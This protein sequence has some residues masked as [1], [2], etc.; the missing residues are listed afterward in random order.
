MRLFVAVDLPET[1]VQSLSELVGRLRALPWTVRWVRP[2]GMHLTMKFIG[3]VGDDRLATIEAALRGATD[4][5]FPFRLAL[6]EPGTFPATGAPRI[7]WVGV[8]GDRAEAV[9]LA[10]AIEAAL[11]PAGVARDGRPFE[12]HLTLGRLRHPPRISADLRALAGSPPREPFAVGDFVLYES[13]LTAEGA[14][15]R[16]LLRVPLSRRGAVI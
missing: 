1:I 12:P 4:L 16:P 7:V 6:G 14:T 5:P 11:L 3:A 8:T 2:E 10:A 9:R 15:Y 13:R